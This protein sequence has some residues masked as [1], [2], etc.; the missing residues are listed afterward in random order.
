[1]KQ[2]RFPQLLVLGRPVAKVVMSAE[3]WIGSLPKP[4]PGR[5]E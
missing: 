5:D 3:A 4:V 2:L 1:V